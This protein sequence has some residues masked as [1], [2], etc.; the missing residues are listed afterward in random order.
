MVS[1]DHINR[2]I[3]LWNVNSSI[4]DYFNEMKSTDTEQCFLLVGNRVPLWSLDETL[5][6]HVKKLTN[7]QS[8]RKS[9]F[10]DWFA[11]TVVGLLSWRLSRD[12]TVPKN[13]RLRYFRTAFSML[14]PNLLRFYLNWNETLNGHFTVHLWNT[15]VQLN[16]SY[17]SHNHR[18]RINLQTL[19]ARYKSIWV[20]YYYDLVLLDV[21][22]KHYLL[23]N[24][25]GYMIR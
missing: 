2:Q 23:V 16:K 24:E 13:L 9:L 8:V 22:I 11:R 12:Y 7:R 14:K 10:T 3:N 17:D 18:Y 15:S 21:L 1:N 25:F 5:N 6:K 20:H 19:F 4:L